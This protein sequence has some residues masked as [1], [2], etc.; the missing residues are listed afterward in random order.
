MES[1]RCIIINDRFDQYPFIASC[2]PLGVLLCISE[3]YL[4]AMPPFTQYQTHTR[5]HVARQGALE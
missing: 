4:V 2:F 3:Q 5:Q 1:L